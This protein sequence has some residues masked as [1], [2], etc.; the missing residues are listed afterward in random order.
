MG[1]R[2]QPHRRTRL[3]RLPFASW[4]TDVSLT[5]QEC[6]LPGSARDRL[7]GLRPPSNDTT[8]NTLEAPTTDLRSL[9][10]SETADLDENFVIHSRDAFWCILHL[11]TT[12]NS[13]G[14][15]SSPLSSSTT[16][17]RAAHFDPQRIREPQPFSSVHDREHFEC[18]RIPRSALQKSNPLRNRQSAPFVSRTERPV[19][20]S[21]F[22]DAI[23]SFEQDFF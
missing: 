16:G 18:P 17:R 3:R 9:D 22:S 12:T 10:R 11:S 21:D 20:T 4:T 15:L 6:S 2:G 1:H 19:I 14:R 7:R 5:E 8:G 23:W 13:L